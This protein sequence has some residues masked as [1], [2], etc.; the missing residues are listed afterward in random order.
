MNCFPDILAEGVKDLTGLLPILVLVGIGL[1]GSMIRK[2]KEEAER[3][4]RMRQGTEAEPPHRN[5]LAPDQKGLPANA[6]EAMARAALRSMGIVAEPQAPPPPKPKLKRAPRA[7]VRESTPETPLGP[8]I[9]PTVDDHVDEH[10]IEGLVK[11]EALV[12]VAA[13]MDLDLSS[14]D[15]LRQA[16]V[17][18]EILGQPK[19]LRR[20]SELWDS[21]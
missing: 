1:V 9:E 14:K 20:E 21:A 11:P 10:I 15:K 17:L 18:R 7:T 3:R 5:E 13:G 16:V 2:R 6:R 19:G 4:E 12:V 8:A